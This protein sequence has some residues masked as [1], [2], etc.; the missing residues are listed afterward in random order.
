M[1]DK[2]YYYKICWFDYEEFGMVELAHEKQFSEE[3]FTKMAD[4]AVR[5]AFEYI[6]KHEP[7]ELIGFDMWY[8]NIDKIDK[9]LADLIVEY[10]KDK[11]GFKE[12]KYT[13]TRD[14][15]GGYIIDEHERE[16]VEK[17][18]GRDLT[19]RIIEHNRKILEKL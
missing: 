6:L 4:E 1:T 15:E 13:A 18:L 16:C 19:D 10:L 2:I 14:Y 7:N 11:Y 12:I 17:I 3:E 9:C 5:H 8:N